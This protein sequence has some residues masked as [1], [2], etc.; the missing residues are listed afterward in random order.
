[1][2]IVFQ[3]VAQ[4]S[5]PVTFSSGSV[6]ANDGK[7]TNILSSMSGATFT[8]GPPAAAPA[9][10]AAVARPVPPPAAAQTSGIS[11]TSIPSIEDSGWYSINNIQFEWNIPIGADG[12]W[13][14]FASS[15]DMAP[16]VTSVASK[17]TSA[18]YDLS[19]VNDGT[20]YFL[21]SSE[22]NGLWLPVVVRTLRLDRT[23]PEP[24]TITRTDSDPADTQLTFTWATVDAL[25]GL[26]HYEIKIGDGDWI[27]PENLQQGSS[28]VVPETTPGKRSLSVRAIDNAGNIQEE[29][30]TFTVVA[31][32]SWQ[33][34]WYQVIKLLSFS[35]IVLAL[36]IVAFILLYYLLSWNL[37]SWKRKTKKEL[38]EFEKELHEEIGQMD[39]DEKEG[40]ALNLDLRPASLEKEK[41]SIKKTAGHLKKAAETEIEKIEKLTGDK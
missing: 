20:W 13:Y 17:T 16:S 2:N 14:A 23:P 3:A 35:L 5:A 40:E 19:S 31:P 32:Q 41:K 26:S 8:I 4:G 7:G 9:G 39:S 10:H 27:D 36:V 18:S 33:E 28:Y 1:V 22:T 30:T 37:L 24:F 25:S 29:D 11:V 6:L 21:I 12:V 38:R 15:S 34:W